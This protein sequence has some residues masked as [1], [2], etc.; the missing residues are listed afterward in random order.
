MNFN[1]R[2]MLCNMNKERNILY[3]FIKGNFF[4]F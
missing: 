2:K 1:F 3:Y 4:L